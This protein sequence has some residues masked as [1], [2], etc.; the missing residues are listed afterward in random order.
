MGAK[1]I[2]CVQAHPVK[3]NNTYNIPYNCNWNWDFL[4]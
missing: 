1:K 3:F 4:K 2:G